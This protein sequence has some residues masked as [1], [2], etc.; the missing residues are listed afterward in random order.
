MIKINESSK[1]CCKP[2]LSPVSGMA[3]LF[4]LFLFSDI[5]ADTTEIRQMS[6]FPFYKVNE[7]SYC[8]GIVIAAGVVVEE[9]E[10]W[11]AMNNRIEKKFFIYSTND[12]TWNWYHPVGMMIDDNKD[13][14]SY[15]A[16]PRH[17]TSLKGCFVAVI[18]V[19][20]NP[21]R[22]QRIHYSRDGIVW[23]YI[24]IHA[25]SVHLINDKIVVEN[26]L[27]F[28]VSD[29]GINW[30][31]YGYNNWDNS[32]PEYTNIVP[33]ENQTVEIISYKDKGENDY[34][35]EEYPFVS[36]DWFSLISYYKDS[37]YVLT[38]NLRFIVIS[39][40]AVHWKVVE[41]PEKYKN[42][43]GLQYANGK[44]Y[45]IDNRKDNYYIQK[46]ADGR[47][48]ESS[49]IYPDNIDIGFEKG[50]R[51][52]GSFEDAI[53]ID[54]LLYL[55]MSYW[56]INS[57]LELAQFYSTDIVSAD[58]STFEIVT[59]DAPDYDYSQFSRKPG[60]IIPE[61]LQEVNRQFKDIVTGKLEPVH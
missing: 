25:T 46:S 17:I 2:N 27:S 21:D 35:S 30:K 12:S 52:F 5:L 60:E 40:D 32:Y 19:G 24:P 6:D 47:K 14:I 7:I 3:V 33:P 20:E 23:H 50:Y 58:G 54:S 49:Q 16:E 42:T 45:F 53:F 51:E 11:D 48:W 34:G 39:K 36:Y 9:T 29:D 59:G 18:D 43:I 22:S 41:V 55:R 57:E 15:D 38:D 31:S 44:I 56:T 61:S 10:K 1:A 8:N 4:F 13:T 37:T 28:S 26:G